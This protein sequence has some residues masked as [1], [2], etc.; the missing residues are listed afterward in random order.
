MS[1]EPDPKQAAPPRARRHRASSTARRDALLAATVE[2][3]AER[4]M[5]GVTH[6]AV[7]EQAGVPLATI[8][9]FFESIDE[10]AAEALRVFTAERV[11]VMSS[12]NT[13]L[14]TQQL[15]FAGMAA[16]FAGA[17]A[18][19]RTQSMAIFEAYLQAGRHPEHRA[20]VADALAALRQVATT[21]LT[22]VGATDPEGAAESYAALVD[23]Y[24]MHALTR[25]NLEVDRVGLQRAIRALFLGELVEAGRIEEAA[26]LSGAYPK[27]QGE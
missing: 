9:Y 20:M 1:A 12:L 19:N 11:R 17:A 26:Q 7:T 14:A 15:D 25:E 4:G 13:V 6:R 5:A 2:V 22:A 18:A 24:A 3:V 10:L 23:G 8:S 21:A 27:P 16:L